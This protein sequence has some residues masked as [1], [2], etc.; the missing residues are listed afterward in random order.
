MCT[1]MYRCTRNGEYTHNCPGHN[2]LTA[3]QGYYISALSPAE[4]HIIMIA[5]FPNDRHGFTV[6][7]GD[8]ILIRR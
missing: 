1:Y 3:R 6:Q 5:K 8:R 2:D 4:A 7:D